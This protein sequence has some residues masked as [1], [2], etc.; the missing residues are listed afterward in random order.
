MR[1]NSLKEKLAAAQRAQADYLV[2][3]DES[4]FRHAPVAALSVA[5]FLALVV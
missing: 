1:L 4:L 2:T 5:D 3:S